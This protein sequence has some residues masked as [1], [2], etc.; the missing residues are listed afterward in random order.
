MDP[1]IGTARAE[2]YHRPAVVNEIEREPRPDDTPPD[3]E[4]DPGP[5]ETEWEERHSPPDESEG[6]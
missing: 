3:E 4:G 1:L 2:R 6:P 5:I